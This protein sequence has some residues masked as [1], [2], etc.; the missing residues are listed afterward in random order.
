ML[1]GVMLLQPHRLLVHL[2]GVAVGLGLGTV[3]RP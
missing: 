1:A 3:A 2:R